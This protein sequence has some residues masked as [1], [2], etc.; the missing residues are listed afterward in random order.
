ML[1]IGSISLD[2]KQLTPL[3]PGRGNYLHGHP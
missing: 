1:G 3:L 2:E